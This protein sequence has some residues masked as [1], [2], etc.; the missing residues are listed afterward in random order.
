MADLHRFIAI[1]SAG[2][3]GLG[4]AWALALVAV[5]RPGERAFEAFQALVVTALVIG[6]AS[7]L[8]RLAGG[9]APREGLHL[10]YAA[11]A[12]ATIPVARSFAGPGSERGRT[13]ALLAAF[14]VLAFLVYR[15]FGT[16]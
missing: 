11:L 13:L 16:G 3:V 9:T 5:G 15:L 14:V 6:A 8:V 1:G 12:L 4:I 10:L 7:G 2:V